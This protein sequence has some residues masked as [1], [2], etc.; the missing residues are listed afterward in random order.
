MPAEH[1]ELRVESVAGHPERLEQ[2]LC[3]GGRSGHTGHGTRLRSSRV[4][5]RGRPQRSVADHA[6]RHGRRGGALGIVALGRI[7]HELSVTERAGR[8]PRIHEHGRRRSKSEAGD[9]SRALAKPAGSRRVSRSPSNL[10]GDRSRGR[11]LLSALRLVRRGAPMAGAPCSPSALSGRS[12][13]WD[14]AR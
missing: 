9:R 6:R 4:P 8:R 14:R 1:P 11:G 10:G 5:P 13:S 2:V 7:D 3:S 12:A